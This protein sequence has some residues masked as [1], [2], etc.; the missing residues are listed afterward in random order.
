MIRDFISYFRIRSGEG[1]IMVY[2][3][4]SERRWR[5]GINTDEI[6]DAVKTYS[7]ERAVEMWQAT[8]EGLIPDFALGTYCGLKNLAATLVSRF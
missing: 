2:K 8:A 7:P 4:I 5:F 6:A 3:G 1:I